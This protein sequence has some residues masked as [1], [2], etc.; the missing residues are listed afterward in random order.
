MSRDLEECET[1]VTDELV[2]TETGENTTAC[3]TNQAIPSHYRN[4]MQQQ[5]VES[6]D[7]AGGKYRY[8][9]NGSSRFIENPRPD[10]LLLYS[11]ASPTFDM[12]RKDK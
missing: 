7:N 5:N 9:M 6:S 2:C 1:A 12:E 3:C 4:M 10:G 8:V 11:L